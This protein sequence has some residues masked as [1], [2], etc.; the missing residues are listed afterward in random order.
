M[1]APAPVLSFPSARR[2]ELAD[3]SRHGKWIM[4]RMLAAFPHLNE[5][6]V[7]AFLQNIIYNNEYHFLYHERAVGLAQVMSEHTLSAQP[8]VIERFVWVEDLQDKEALAQAAE[9]YV[10]FARWARH[11]GADVLIVEEMTD[12]PHEMIK[13]KL[14][15][16]FERVQKFARTK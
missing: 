9:F 7:A 4:P 6:G 1:N 13:D 11:Q 2:F 15:R 12:V 5:R 10:S 16:V 8:V 14:G 3:L